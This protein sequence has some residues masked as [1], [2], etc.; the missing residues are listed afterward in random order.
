MVAQRAEGIGEGKVT[1]QQPTQFAPKLDQR[2]GVEPPN[3][4]MTQR[5][6]NHH[7]DHTDLR[8]NQEEVVRIDRLQDHGEAHIDLHQ[9]QEDLEQAHT[10]N[11]RH[12]T[13][14]TMLDLHQIPLPRMARD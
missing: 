11:Q 8:Q 7:V 1:A 6:V 12:G 14:P 3:A 13:L 9:D 10:K 4:T 2:A 5:E